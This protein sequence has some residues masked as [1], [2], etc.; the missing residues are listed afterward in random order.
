MQSVRQMPGLLVG[1][2]L[3]LLQVCS[4]RI[5][6]GEAPVCSNADSSDGNCAACGL[7]LAP[8]TTKTK[9]NNISSTWA[10]YTG[11]LRKPNDLVVEPDLAIDIMDANKNEWSPWHEVVFSSGVDAVNATPSHLHN[12]FYH[13]VFLPGIAS[14]ADCAPDS[15]VNLIPTDGVIDTA[16]TH[17]SKDATVGSFST[18]FGHSFRANQEL[19]AGDRLFM[20]CNRKTQQSLLSTP[21]IHRAGTTHSRSLEWL[22]TNAI[23]LDTLSVQTSQI[24]SAGRGAFSKMRTRIGQPIATTP[25]LHL[26]K[27]Q[28]EIYEQSYQPNQRIPLIRNH[29]ILY[30]AQV[31]KQLQLLAN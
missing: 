14:L 8:V 26:D 15:L 19:Q 1:M 20:S 13:D 5:V 18:N 23:C 30:N 2:L 24:P 21:K 22:A 3:L 16:G 29:G 7:Y 27:S 9:G 28:V 17:R 12:D 25:L 11:L 4:F 10:L 31:V 6:S